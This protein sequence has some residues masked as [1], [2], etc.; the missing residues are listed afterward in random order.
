MPYRSVSAPSL[1]VAALFLCTT[2]L[3][4]SQD[5]HHTSFPQG[6]FLD[7]NQK[8]MRLMMAGMDVKPSGDVD[9]DFAAMMIPHHQGAIDMAR[10][11][12]AYGKNERLRRIAQEII[13]EQ[14]AEIIA[15]QMAA[16]TED[17]VGEL[18]RRW[19]PEVRRWIMQ[20]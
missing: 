12:L 13:V 16:H 14:K 9:Q 3:V 17:R 5:P 20:Q 6:P 15:M 19:T 1:L 18:E 4:R 11:E 8:A 7:A 10:A 2:S